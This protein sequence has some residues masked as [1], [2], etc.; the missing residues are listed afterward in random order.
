MNSF[1]DLTLVEKRNNDTYTAVSREVQ[2][3]CF[4]AKTA[5]LGDSL[6]M[7]RVGAA[8][9]SGTSLTRFWVQSVAGPRWT[10]RLE[11]CESP[12][13]T[14]ATTQHQTCFS[15]AIKIPMVLAIPSTPRP[16]CLIP[17]DPSH[18]TCDR[19][20]PQIPRLLDNR[21]S[22]LPESVRRRQS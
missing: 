10:S 18:P 2:Y 5:R 8:I 17:H 9:K 7:V 16:R 3:P 22:Y 1:S 20:Q 21:P 11:S 12:K 19:A 6:C 15:F 13:P 4:F 14:N